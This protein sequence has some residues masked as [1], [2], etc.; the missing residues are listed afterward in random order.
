MWCVSE[1]IGGGG[2]PDSPLLPAEA[3]RDQTTGGSGW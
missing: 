1:G 2:L 3:A